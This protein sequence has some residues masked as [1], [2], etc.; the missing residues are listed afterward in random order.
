M[1]LLY[2]DCRGR[3][4]P[5]R[6][7]L[8]DRAIEFEDEQVAS[9]EGNPHWPALKA[10]RSRTGPFGTL[11][12]FH[13]GNRMVAETEVIVRY[14]QQQ[15]GIQPDLTNAAD[16]RDATA[17]SAAADTRSWA[18]AAVRSSDASGMK[19]YLTWAVDKYRRLDTFVPDDQP[20]F[21]GDLPSFADFYSM[22]A[23]FDLKHLCGEQAELFLQELPKLHDLYQRVAA[24][25]GIVTGWSARPERLGGLVDELDVL[26]GLGDVD[27]SSC[28]NTE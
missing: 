5:I 7:F 28:W 22:E 25:P 9:T 8:A 1:R 3:A 26:R 2:W 21:G 15:Q 27:W 17:Q 18:L 11:P 20:Y 16:L 4:Q 19:A 24:R 10:D 12:V 23:V 13:D 14:L 6:D